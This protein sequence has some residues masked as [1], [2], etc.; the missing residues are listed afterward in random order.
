MMIAKDLLEY[1]EIKLSKK[2]GIHTKRIQNLQ[3]LIKKI[4]QW[5]SIKYPKDDAFGKITLL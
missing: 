4:L 1:D 5:L 3:V 2:T